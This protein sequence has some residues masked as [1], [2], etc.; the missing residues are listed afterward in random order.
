VPFF[1]HGGK[2]GRV[3]EYAPLI[4]RWGRMAERATRGLFMMLVLA[5]VG[6][7][8]AT[9]VVAK[10]TLQGAVP[11]TLIAG[12]LDLR[13][14]EN[15]DTAFSLSRDFASPAKGWVILAMSCLAV[16]AVAAAWWKRRRQARLLEHAAF[17][18]VVGGAIGNVLDRLARG[19]VVD[20]IHLR[21]WPV[22][23]VADVAICAGGVLVGLAL[24][25]S[26]ASA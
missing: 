3:A 1:H 23:N 4:H 11:R 5:L 22:F 14:A 19:Y 10:V 6:C 15:R 24:M 9:K 7:D 2:S 18:L 21:W 8:H 12:V 25:R 16:A 17:V 20:F 26:T 13:Y